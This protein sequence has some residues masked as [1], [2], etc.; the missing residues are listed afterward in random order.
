M[1][2]FGFR[3]QAVANVENYPFRQTFRLF[4][5]GRVSRPALYKAARNAELLHIHPKDGNA[6]FSEMLDNF[7]HQTRII[8]KARV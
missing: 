5:S 7:Q 2:N 3:G 8:P 1:Y 6:E 4:S